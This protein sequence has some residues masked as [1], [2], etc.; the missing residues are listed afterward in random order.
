MQNIV[1][2]STT[3]AI[4]LSLIVDGD[5]TIK[6]FFDLD[7]E[8]TNDICCCGFKDELIALDN[9][10]FTKLSGALAITV[11]VSKPAKIERLSVSSLSG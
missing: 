7:V 1:G 11:P 6:H 5:C 2:S 3:G 10:V 8:G 4:D 9:L